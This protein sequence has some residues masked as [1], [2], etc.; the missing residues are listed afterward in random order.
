MVRQLIRSSPILRFAAT[1]KDYGGFLLVLALD[2][3]GPVSSRLDI[4]DFA[5]RHIT[6]P[7]TESAAVCLRSIG[8]RRYATLLVTGVY[9]QGV[10]AT[11]IR[12][13]K[14]YP[15]TVG[16]LCQDAPDVFFH[17]RSAYGASDGISKLSRTVS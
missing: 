16:E 11:H 9:P 14:L 1:P 15:A 4:I 13:Q 10:Q 3:V 2:G 6:A 5:V 8:I 7:W 17:V 12:W